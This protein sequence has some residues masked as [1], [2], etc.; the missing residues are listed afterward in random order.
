LRALPRPAN[1]QAMC[2]KSVSGSVKE[3]ARI[4]DLTADG[5]QGAQQGRGRDLA[6]GCDLETACGA[7]FDWEIT[8]ESGAGSTREE[9]CGAT[10]DAHER[11]A[12]GL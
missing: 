1:Q 5:A 3:I 8:S 10:A 6:I 9:R 7:S 11:A 12:A 4:T 2:S